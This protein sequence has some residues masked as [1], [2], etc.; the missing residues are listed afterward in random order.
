MKIDD[1]L[2]RCQYYDYIA[3]G[4]NL[5]Q[6]FPRWRGVLLV[7][8]PQ[9]MALY[10]QAIF[11]N[12]P[13]WIVETGTFHGGSAL[14]FGDLLSITGGKGVISIDH[15]KKYRSLH[16]MVEYIT[17][18]SRDRDMFRNL[19]SKLRDSRGSVMVSLDSKHLTGHVSRELE[20]YHQLVTPGQYLVVEDCWTGSNPEPYTPYP[21]VQKFLE[22]HPE[23]ELHHPEEQFIFAVTR[24]G[25]LWRKPDKKCS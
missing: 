4:K 13:D 17:T 23:F 2:M 7:K 3:S 8:F 22:K 5:H 19:R 9:D 18:D 21:A 10:A 15:L 11:A 25:W 1:E 16:K 24:D 6:N 12:K 14:Y 20:L